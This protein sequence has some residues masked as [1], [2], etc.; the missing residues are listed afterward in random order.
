MPLVSIHI[1]KGVRSPSEVLRL[2]KT[3]HQS[4]QDSFKT[5]SKD[6]LHVVIQHEPY[7]L[8]L[9]DNGLGF[10]RT[11]KRVLICITQQGRTTMDKT[12]LYE[13]LA[14]NLEKECGVQDTDLMISL[15]ANEKSDWSF[16]KG[17][18]QLL[19]EQE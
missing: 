2:S 5:S 7:E 6:R 19:E 18:P 1:I 16:E 14:K 9:E 8:I 17:R 11:E 15:T 10:E 13:T 3:V 12:A 4:L